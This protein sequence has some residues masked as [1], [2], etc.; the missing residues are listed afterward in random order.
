MDSPNYYEIL[1]VVPHASPEVIRAAYKS[2]M[3]RHHPDRHPAHSDAA[4]RTSAIAQAYAVLSDAAQRAAYDA[5]LQQWRQPPV[6]AGYAPPIRRAH[7]VPTAAASNWY[8]WLLAAVILASGGLMLVLSG[9]KSPPPPAVL[10]VP[11]RPTGPARSD[12]PDTTAA[13]QPAVA[14]ALQRMA[15]LAADLNVVLLGTDPA[16]ES[17]RHRL[18]IPAIELLIGSTESEKFA[19]AL[20]RQKEQV[21]Q[22]LAEKLA[23]AA[24]SELLFD[25]DRYL[26]PFILDALREITGTQ[27]LDGGAAGNPTTTADTHRYGIVAV[28]LPASFGLR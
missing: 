1:E 25:G 22:K 3:Q 20:T 5:R 4:S 26:A 18:S 13:A 21:V 17:S 10:A 8:L 16:A 6:P 14:P 7:A 11:Q 12:T 9:H 23:H 27:G 2:L 28:T 24:Y 19:D 15:L